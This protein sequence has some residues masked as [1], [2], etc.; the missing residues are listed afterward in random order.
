MDFAALPVPAK[1]LTKVQARGDFVFFVRAP[2]DDL[3]RV[4]GEGGVLQRL[5]FVAGGRIQ[6]SRSSSLVKMTGIAFGQQ[7]RSATSSGIRRPGG[8]GDWLR[9]RAARRSGSADFTSLSAG[10]ATPWPSRP[11][12]LGK[13]RG[14]CCRLSR[15][16]E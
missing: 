6:T 2:Y 9:R 11:S 16:S 7:S 5:R 12:P 8:A 10:S 15:A 13:K 3:Q 14:P 1:P 4:I